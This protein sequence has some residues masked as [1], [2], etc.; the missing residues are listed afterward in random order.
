MRVNAV[1]YTAND[2]SLKRSGAWRIYYFTRLPISEPVSVS[3]AARALGVVGTAIYTPRL[4]PWMTISPQAA[5]YLVER[6]DDSRAVAKIRR[7]PE[8]GIM[9]GRLLGKPPYRYIEG[10]LLDELDRLLLLAAQ[11][12]LSVS[13]SAPRYRQQVHDMNTFARRYEQHRAHF[14]ARWFVEQWSIAPKGE[15]AELAPDALNLASASEPR[16][17]TPRDPSAPRGAGGS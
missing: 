17:G 2:D 8:V 14:I 7:A 10:S 4:P 15:G 12:G 16:T 6:I 9:Q 13:S 5:E 1:L 11:A 3:M